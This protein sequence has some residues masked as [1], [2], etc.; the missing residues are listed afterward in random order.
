MYPELAG[1]RAL[2][3]GAARG[4]GRA[5]AI[6]LASE[7]VRVV[8]NYRRSMNDAAKV[9]EEIKADG[10]DAVAIRGDVGKEE[11][12]DKLFEAI[13]AE[14]GG[15]DI[16]VANAAFGVPGTLLDT[17]SKHWD[18]TMASSAR[19]LLDLTKRALPL[20]NNGWGRIISITS[21]GGQK[22]IP[23]YGIVG[24]AKGALES[25]TRGLAYELAGKNIVVNGVLAGLADTKS[26][27]SIPG[28]DEVIAHAQFHTPRGRIVQPEDVAKAVAFLASNEA[29]MI[30]GQFIVVDGGR[31]I[32]S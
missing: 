27:R 24:P 5:I 19:S 7:G 21:D 30:C 3:T 9:V 13:K 8:V 23:G 10:G 6:R 29:D 31:D 28:S 12:L 22:V 4:F 25:I 14:F 1:K 2:V 11:S 17:T 15:L 18:I 16:V 26:A 20:M 32:M